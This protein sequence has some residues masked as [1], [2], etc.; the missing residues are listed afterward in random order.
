MP[1]P[2]KSHRGAAKRVR[3]GARGRVKVNR[4]SANHLKSGKTGKLRRKH[5]HARTLTGRQAQNLLRVLGQG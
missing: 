4:I 3:V 1:H 5:R 2:M